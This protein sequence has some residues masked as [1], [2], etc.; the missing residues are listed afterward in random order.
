MFL[1]GVLLASSC[2]AQLK[3]DT[4]ESAA[5]VVYGGKDND[6]WAFAVSGP[7]GWKFDCCDIAKHFGANLLV[8]PNGWDNASPDQVMILTVWS[9]TNAD[10][11]ADWEADA[12]DYLTRFPHAKA[13]SFPVAVQGSACRS[14]VYVADDHVRDYVVFCDPGADWRYRFGW[15]M[16]LDRKHADLT[17]IEAAFQGVVSR[18]KPM[19]S[20]IEKKA[21]P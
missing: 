8:F 7:A 16:L 11:G 21:S 12:Q 2:A 19:H 9:K 13:E 17:K 10:V 5:T 1:A 20:S 15:T 3:Q 18:T 14:G 6:G 4:D